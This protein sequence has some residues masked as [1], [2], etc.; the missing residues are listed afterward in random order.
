M[1]DGESQLKFCECVYTCVFIRAQGCASTTFFWPEIA[2]LCLSAGEKSGNYFQPICVS[3]SLATST[4]AAASA[5]LVRLQNMRRQQ[6]SEKVHGTPLG[7]G[8]PQ[9]SGR[10]TQIHQADPLDNYHFNPL[11]LSSGG[12]Y[13]THFSFLHLIV[14]QPAWVPE[15]LEIAETKGWQA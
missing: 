10:D 7:L 1:M 6:Q 8:R 12:L 11:S 13:K 4:A 9:A 3:V 14:S 2:Q 5:Y 15:F